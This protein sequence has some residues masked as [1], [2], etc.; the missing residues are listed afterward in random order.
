M[1]LVGL[2]FKVHRGLAAGRAVEPRAVLKDFEIAARALARVAKR[3]RTFLRDS[4]QKI[5]LQAH[6]PR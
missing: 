5:S 2:S 4:R 3:L 6:L 1:S